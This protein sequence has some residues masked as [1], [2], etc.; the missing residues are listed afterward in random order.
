MEN[1]SMSEDTPAHKRLLRLP[2][3]SNRIGKKRSSIYLMIANSEFPNPI[4]LGKRSVGWL[5]EEI[6]AWI[7]ARV[8]ASRQKERTHNGK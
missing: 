6:N 4:K 3:V 7:D 8:K 1:Q 2:D 5:E